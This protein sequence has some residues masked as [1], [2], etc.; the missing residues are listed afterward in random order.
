MSRGAILRA[1]AQSRGPHFILVDDW[2]ALD[3][4]TRKALCAWFDELAKSGDGQYLKFV[5]TTR[6]WKAEELPLRLVCAN[7][8]F[9]FDSNLARDNPLLLDK[10]VA[11]GQP[12]LA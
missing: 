7:G 9:Y 5:L 1:A 11:H 10:A 6:Y 8:L 2:S 12:R 4:D 3:Q